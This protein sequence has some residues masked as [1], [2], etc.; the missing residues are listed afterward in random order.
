MIGNADAGWM[1][2]DARMFSEREVEK[3]TVLSDGLARC[4]E[5]GEHHG[6]SLRW[7]LV[8]GLREE[9]EENQN[10]AKSQSQRWCRES[11]VLGKEQ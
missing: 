7:L 9:F 2:C 6:E 11:V 3:S 10:M 8:G 4:R 1:K 5:L